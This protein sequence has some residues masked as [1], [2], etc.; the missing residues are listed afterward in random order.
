VFHTHDRHEGNHAASQAYLDWEIGL[1]AR[2]AEDE[3]ATFRPD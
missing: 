2:L 1:I 3:R